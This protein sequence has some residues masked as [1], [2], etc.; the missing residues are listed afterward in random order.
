MGKIGYMKI[1]AILKDTDNKTY[2]STMVAKKLSMTMPIRAKTAKTLAKISARPYLSMTTDQMEKGDEK[3]NCEKLWF[4]KFPSF[5]F[6]HQSQISVEVTPVPIKIVIAKV[7][8]YKSLYPKGHIITG[9]L[10]IKIDK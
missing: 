4:Q 5:C 9:K 2:W 7:F 6:T 10:I 1:P 8:E 3:E